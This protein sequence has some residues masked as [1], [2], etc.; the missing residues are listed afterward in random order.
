MN[1]GDFVPRVSK[2][3]AIQWLNRY[4]DNVCIDKEI[5]RD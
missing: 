3:L 4:N 5:T 2:D 1:N